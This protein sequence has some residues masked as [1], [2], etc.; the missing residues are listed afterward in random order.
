MK[1][2]IDKINI[3]SIKNDLNKDIKPLIYKRSKEAFDKI[4]DKEKRLF[5]P[6]YMFLF[7]FFFSLLAI[8]TFFIIL[9]FWEKMP[10]IKKR[11]E[12]R[13]KLVL[14]INGEELFSKAT[15]SYDLI[16]I[17]NY[18]KDS[19]SE[20][21]YLNRRKG[22][23]KDATVIDSSPIV[24]LKLLD[25]HDSVLRMGRM[26]WVRNYGRQ[27]KV[28]YANTAYMIIS[29]KNISKINNFSLNYKNK[30]RKGFLLENNKFNK[31]FQLKTSEKN[32]INTAM[33]FT[34]LVMEQ[35]NDI[36]SL[37][38]EFHWNYVAKKNEIKIIWKPK[39]WQ[40]CYAS[41]LKVNFKNSENISQSIF[42]EI[43]SNI[44][45]LSIISYIAMLPLLD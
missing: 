28:Y 41:G 5:K 14:I 3:E 35:Y 10:F 22:I 16:S 1:K 17:K 9:G 27:T 11:K 43:V 25:E 24:K 23:P 29:T 32:K 36:N 44:L 39:W 2:V 8:I 19:S 21:I 7:W 26:R 15:E 6:F 37:A 12:V 33:T 18:L 42:N 30:F 40:D 45:D 34:P 38:N 20:D 13:K 4:T 31:N